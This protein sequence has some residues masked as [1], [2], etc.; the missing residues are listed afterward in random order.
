MGGLIDVVDEVG[1]DFF[2]D[3]LPELR[4]FLIVLAEKLGGKLD[5]GVAHVFAA[6]IA[7]VEDFGG[8]PE[9]VQVAVDL[10]ADVGFAT[11]GN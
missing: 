4:K 1:D 7:D 8:E 3:L 2:G 10:L 5:V 9:P 11:R 6:E